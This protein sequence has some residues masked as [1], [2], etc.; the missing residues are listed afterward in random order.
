MK[1]HGRRQ[2]KLRLCSRLACM[3]VRPSLHT[4]MR[5]AHQGTT[6][7]PSQPSTTCPSA[8]LVVAADSEVAPAPRSGGGIASPGGCTSN[9]ALT[10]GPTS[11]DSMLVS[12]CSHG[13]HGREVK[14]MLGARHDEQAGRRRLAAAAAGRRGG[15][16]IG[17][18]CQRSHQ[19]PQLLQLA[20]HGCEGAQALLANQS[21]PA[22][23]AGRSR[24]PKHQPITRR[25]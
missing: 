12:T 8:R 7:Q 10:R 16:G 20:G 21:G 1:W 18:G 3:A 11:S 4:H 14:L 9:T 23:P 24:G 13:R 25:S 19:L 15:G 22:L 5:A 6:Q 17:R 2:G